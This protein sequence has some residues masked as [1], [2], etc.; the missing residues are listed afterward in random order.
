MQIDKFIEIFFEKA[1]KRGLDEFEVYYGSGKSFSVK[2]FDGEVD[3]YKNSQGLGL[4]FRAIYNGQMGYSYTENFDES[5]VDM[6]IDEAI[7][8][9]STL[10]RDS[11]E[12]IYNGDKE[13]E[14]INN[15]NDAIEKISSEVKIDFAKK[16]EAEAKKLDNRVTSVNYCLYGEGSG[17]RII[18]NSKGLRL[19]DKGN[20]AYC[21]LSVVVK[22]N[23]DTKTGSAYRLSKNFDDFDAKEIA[24]EAV[25]EAISLLGAKPIDSGEYDVIIRNKTFASLLGAMSG[26]FSAEAVEKGLSKLEGKIG[27]QIAVDEFNLVDNPHMENGG[28]SRAF[29]DEGVATTCKK[30]IENGILK[31]YLHN[32]KTAKKA[33]I[34]STGNGQKGSYKSGINIAPFNFYLEPG[35]LSLE[36][37]KNKMDK[38]LLLI[39]FGGLHSGLNGI[40]GDFSLITSGYYIENGKIIRPVNQITIGG[41][42]F[43]LLK[44]ID[45]IGA[46]LEFNLPGV[47]TI[48]SPSVLIKNMKIGGK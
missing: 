11:L 38:G 2:I 36:Q 40:S 37:M 43:D 30:L 33:G 27:M 29:D 16:L 42:Y 8:G 39:E 10:E 17:E 18:M 47:A 41:N 23:E 14:D 44:K 15:Y 12:E 46:D 7:D 48:G 21:Y 26:I 20:D 32:L 45:T 22:E 3:D 28:S 24:K 4:S 25:E 19:R 13:Y 5:S 35:T 6:L 1:Q 9:A 31:G 34:K